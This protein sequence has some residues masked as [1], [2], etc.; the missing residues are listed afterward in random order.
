MSRKPVTQHSSRLPDALDEQR[1]T[2]PISTP[3]SRKRAAS[4]Q[5]SP[6]PQ[7]NSH[8]T[9]AQPCTPA[10]PPR[11]KRM[12]F[13]PDTPEL[14]RQARQELSDT[15]DEH[16]ETTE[17]EDYPRDVKYTLT[18]GAPPPQ[19]NGGHSSLKKYLHEM[20]NTL[21]NPERFKQK[22]DA[23]GKDILDH[24][25]RQCES[26]RHAALHAAWST[27]QSRYQL[28]RARSGSLSDN[29]PDSDS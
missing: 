4:L 25:V 26:H 23:M 5:E 13:N 11:R 28:L 8:T 24:T 2:S 17:E 27:G 9:I 20:A 29:A 16:G 19:Y 14:C 10:A 22:Y 18:K 1:Q 21:D 12:R 15:E 3:I 7:R 6:T